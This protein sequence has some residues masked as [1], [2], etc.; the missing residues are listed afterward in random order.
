[1]R[2]RRRPRRGRR[3]SPASSVRCS[4]VRREPAPARAGQSVGARCAR[5]RAGAR[6]AA[7][8]AARQSRLVSPRD[9]DVQ[10]RRA[11]VFRRRAD[12]ALRLQ[13]RR[14]VQVVRARRGA[15]SRVADAALGHVARARHQH[16]RHG[17]GRA[18]EAGATR[19]SRK[20]RSESPP[21][22]MWSRALVDA[23]AKRYV[24][25]ADGRS[26]RRASRR[27]RTRWARCRSSFPDD[28]DVATLYA[29]SMM[30]LRPWRL[31]KKDG[32]PEPGTD[33][34]VAS[35]ES[36]MKREP[37]SPG[38][39]SLLHPRRR[40]LEVARA[41]AAAGAPARDARARRRTSR[42]H[43]RAHL[44]SHRAVREV[45]EEQRGCGRVSTRSTS[46]R[47]APRRPLSD[48]V[49]Q[50][51]PAVRIRSGD[52]CRQPR[53]GAL[54]RRAHGEVCRSDR[55]S[56]GD[57]GAVRGAGPRGAGPLRTVGRRFSRPSRLLRRA[58]CRPRSIT[59]RT[60]PRLPRPARSRRPRPSSPRF[61]LV[62]QD[63]EGRDDRLSEYRRRRDRCG[64]RRSRRAHRRC[65][66]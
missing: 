15:R 65:E 20:P 35:L 38:R 63:P 40:S 54:G 8:D 2:V 57:G 34:I 26:G 36:V 56:D 45:G 13:P 60:A 18:T 51:Q 29:E 21:A 59:S 58:C 46:R 7:H 32:T 64:D 55:R 49:L 24:A 33:T 31:Y 30:N 19:I 53:A 50:A 25:D 37:E 5:R 44:H 43:A 42:P 9:Q 41:R 1:M 4:S 12:A 14:V 11:E 39:E 62:G 27:T 66:G 6:S 28:L 52:V 23:L 17:A 10:R 48:D 3:R 16:Q 61:G 22:A 47:P